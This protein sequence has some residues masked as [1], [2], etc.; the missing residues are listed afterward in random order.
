MNAGKIRPMLVASICAIVIVALSPP[1]QAA[2]NDIHA[3]KHMIIIM[4]ENRSFDT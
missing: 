1:A 4:Q 3:I 2:T